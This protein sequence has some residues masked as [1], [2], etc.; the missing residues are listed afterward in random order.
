MPTILQ[1]GEETLFQSII[2]SNCSDELEKFICYAQFSP[3]D[4]K[5][6]RTIQIPCKSLCVRIHKNC[7]KE[8]NK[9]GLPLPPCDYV[10]PED[11]NNPTGICE[12]KKWPA[13][14]PAQFRPPAP[15]E[16]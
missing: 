3:C 16:C 10:Y 1:T 5:Q 12:V 8:F 9:A 6:P 15:G 14:W 2:N 13:S 11:D 7:W 4:P